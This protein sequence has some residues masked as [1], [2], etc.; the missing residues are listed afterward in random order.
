MHHRHRTGAQKLKGWVTA[1]E[2]LTSEMKKGCIF[3]NVFATGPDII[4]PDFC[5]DTH[6]KRNGLNLYGCIAMSLLFISFD[7]LPDWRTSYLQTC[8]C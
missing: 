6:T 5:Q 3:S 2:G 7:L 1:A 4:C 8:C